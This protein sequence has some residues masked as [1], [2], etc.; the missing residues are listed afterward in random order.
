MSPESR[1]LKKESSWN[2]G[3]DTLSGVSLS[4]SL[5]RESQGTEGWDSV[6]GLLSKAMEGATKREAEW[7]DVR[8]ASRVERIT[9]ARDRKANLDSL[10]DKLRAEGVIRGRLTP[11]SYPLIV[12]ASAWRDNSLRLAVVA[13]ELAAEHNPI[14]LRGLFYRVVSAGFLPSTAKPHYQ[15]LMRIVTTLREARVMPFSWIVDN[16]RDTEKP[17]SWSGLADFAETTRDAYR[18][19]FW[20]SLPEYAHIFCEKD[21]MSGII[22]PVTREYDVPL[23]VIR[24]YTSV[25]YAAH[26]AEQWEAI[27]KPIRAYYLGDLDPSG[28]DLERDLREKLERYCR[29]PFTWTR[30]GVSDGDPEQFD[31]IPL[32][33]KDS[34]RRAAS[35]RATG[36]TQCYELDAIPPRDLRNRLENAIRN[37]I[38]TEQWDRLLAV[39]EAER[40][41]WSKHVLAFKGGIA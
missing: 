22:A 19:D 31:L 15:T 37:H 40:E 11:E 35:Y 2:S 39:E 16:I 14:T 18:L 21:A 3:Q 38:P 33:V 8:V 28:L 12:G 30:L 25:S 34:D 23:S 7:D 10:I 5:S 26:I 27:E 17:T 20:H 4:R 29:R 13:S 6:L 32:A 1:S 41:S 24:G 9:R 36:R